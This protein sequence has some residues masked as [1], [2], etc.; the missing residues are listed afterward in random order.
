MSPVR[1]EAERN[2]KNVAVLRGY[3]KTTSRLLAGRTCIKNVAINKG[4]K[5]RVFG[6]MDKALEWLMPEKG[7]T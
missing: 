5:L 4:R 2:T 3:G 1:A 6:E 7:H